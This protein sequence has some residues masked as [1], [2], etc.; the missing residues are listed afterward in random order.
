MGTEFVVASDCS[1]GGGEHRR[2]ASWRTR[3]LGESLVLCTLSRQLFLLVDLPV[4]SLLS[5]LP[6]TIRLL[7]LQGN[8]A[9]RI[10][11][12]APRITITCNGLADKSVPFLAWYD[13]QCTLL[14]ELTPTRAFV[15]SSSFVS[16]QT[17]KQLAAVSPFNPVPLP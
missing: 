13:C 2:E 9:A 6:I 10:T 12:H 15:C 8:Y 11:H 3:G 1:R 7:I 14:V 16:H 4:K 17:S 5:L